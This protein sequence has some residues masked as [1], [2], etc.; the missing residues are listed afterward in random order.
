MPVI[1]TQGSK[2]EPI[3]TLE[4]SVCGGN[5]KSLDDADLDMTKSGQVLDCAHKEEK[6]Q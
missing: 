2:G 1:V 6:C 3:V 4:C 5:I